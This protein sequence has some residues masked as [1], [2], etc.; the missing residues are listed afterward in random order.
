MQ[1]FGVADGDTKKQKRTGPKV[2]LLVSSEIW[3]KW[4]SV[5]PYLPLG[6]NILSPTLCHLAYSCLLEQFSFKRI[7]PILFHTFPHFYFLCKVTHTI[8]LC[9]YILII[10]YYIDEK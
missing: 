10:L 3:T 7:F 8:N 4:R 1:I 2:M 9:L 6:Y 5:T